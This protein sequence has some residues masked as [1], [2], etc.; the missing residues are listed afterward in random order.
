MHKLVSK[1]GYF[2]KDI[3]KLNKSKYALLNSFIGENTFS[4][5]LQTQ[6]IS[7]SIGIISK[8]GVW[9]KYLAITHAQNTLKVKESI[10]LLLFI[11]IDSSTQNSVMYEY[12][13]S[14]VNGT[15]NTMTAY[16]ISEIKCSLSQ[17]SLFINPSDDEE[18]YVVGESVSQK[19]RIAKVDRVENEIDIIEIDNFDRVMA[20]KLVSNQQFISLTHSLS[21]NQ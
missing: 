17:W 4:L 6:L 8:H 5:Y 3:F 11:G 21:G 16:E 10:N 7:G 12:D 1:N 9:Q 2:C 18:A 19:F 14:D 20:S 15:S 13:L